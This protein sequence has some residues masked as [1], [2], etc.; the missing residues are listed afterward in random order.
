MED[1]NEVISNTNKLEGNLVYLS[2]SSAF[3]DCINNMN[4]VDLRFVGLK[5]TWSNLQSFNSL[6]LERLDRALTNSRWKVLF[7]NNVVLH[8]S[9]LSDDHC[10]ILMDT[11][12]MDYPPLRRFRFES[13]WLSHPD[14]QNVV[15]SS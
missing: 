15:S 5:F 2:R 14:F 9:R 6:I 11:N 10:P 12:P 7:L 13:M 3:S 4:M 1:F 8:L